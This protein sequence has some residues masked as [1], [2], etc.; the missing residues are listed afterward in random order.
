VIG[1]AFTAL[2][3]AAAVIITAGAVFKIISHIATI[4]VGH[5]HPPLDHAVGS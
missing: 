1:K 5:I 2:T 4:F 3:L